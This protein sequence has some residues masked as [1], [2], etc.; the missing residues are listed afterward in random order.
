MSG[1]AAYADPRRPVAAIRDG[2]LVDLGS[3]GP[4]DALVS[5]DSP[6]GRAVLRHSAAHVVAKAIVR[7]WPG[8][9]LAVGPATE[10][11]FFYD[12]RLPGGRTL[13]EADLVAI[14]EEVRRIVEADEPFQR[15]ELDLSSA[16]ALL[17]D[18]PF[19]LEILDR[20]EQGEADVDAV[21]G[22]SVSVYATG[23]DFVDLCR[24]PHVP[25]T[26]HLRALEVLRVSG[27]YW[28]GDEH[29]PQL[30]RVSGTAFETVEA[31]EAWRTQLAEAER[32]DHRRVG[33][34]LGLF[35][36]PNEVGGGLPIFEP[37]G[38]WVRYRLEE[39]SRQLHFQAGYLP[40]WT[41][42]VTRSTLF[43]LSGHLGWYRESMYPPMELEDQEYFLKPMS[44]PMHI[45]AYRQHLRSYRELPLRLFELATV[46]RY[47]RSGTLHGL[48]RV[49]SL[50]QDDAHIFC[51]A[52]QLA[53]ELAGVVD[54]VVRLLGAFGLED[55]EAELSTRP[56]KSV[57]SDEDW[58]FATDAAATALERSGLSYR[59][60][61]GEGAFYAPKIDIHLRDAIGRRWQ[62][63]TI[64]VDLQLPQ[65]FDLSYQSAANQ[66]ERPFMIHRAIF[67]SVER[68]LAILLEHFDGMLPTWLVRE[69][70]R[71]LPVAAEA[72][73]WAETVRGELAAHGVRAR[74]EA[75]DEPLGARVRR[76]RSERVPYI[77]VV[78]AQDVAAGTVGLTRPDRSQVRGAVL[79]D[80][81]DEIRAAC[82]TPEVGR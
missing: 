47:E 62:L 73:T 15:R 22:T 71:I 48:A 26:G 21:A 56:A 32:R 66:L 3:A 17:A 49:R 39:F 12:V 58:A 35:F 29:G 38:G 10:E 75:A 81:L 70:V 41:P 46:Y 20:I 34:Q 76:A 8:T 72:E 61:P 78:G 45:L 59:L 28:R 55:F 7:L 23:D 63:S 60:A 33:A 24:G 67:G 57:G 68:F 25:S 51:R 31:L 53:D 18:Q 4:E 64:Q 27:A 9:Q 82:A 44:C 37:D 16:R 19:K 40:V 14:Q 42:H 2:E 52:D 13:D 6:R 11:G 79:A 69:P 30:Q 77:L 36:F 80:V 1:G 74:I 5:A 50:T 43:E 54:L 65:R